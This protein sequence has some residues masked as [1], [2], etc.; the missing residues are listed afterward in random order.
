MS[1][2]AIRALPEKWKAQGG[3]CGGSAVY[4]ARLAIAYGMTGDFDAAARTLKPVHPGQKADAYMLEYARLSVDYLAELALNDDPTEASVVRLA[5]AFGEFVSKHPRFREAQ[6][7]LGTLQTILGKR[8]EA[9]RSGLEG[10]DPET[11]MSGA[12]RNL[13]VNYSALGKHSDA[14][15]A[16]EMACRLGFD[17]EFVYAAARSLAAVGSYP[18]AENMMDLLRERTPAA[19]A[20]PEFRETVELITRAGCHL[21]PATD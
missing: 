3:D 13:T 7:M 4:E 15:K 6:A 12:Y 14:A 10:L 11:D 8:E 2:E 21:P 18:P 5:G 9:I 1:P 19:A 20:A 16:A 17:Q